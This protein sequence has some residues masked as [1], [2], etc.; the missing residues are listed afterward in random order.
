MVQEKSDWLFVFHPQLQACSI[1]VIQEW[2]I[3][4]AA[5]CRS[6]QKSNIWKTNISKLIKK[7]INWCI[8]VIKTTIIVVPVKTKKIDVVK[9]VKLVEI[10]PKWDKSSSL[11]WKTKAINSID[12]IAAK[13]F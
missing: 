12:E 7:K 5:I 13:S 4:N 2:D 9:N 10:E 11:K 8:V 3:F 6:G 1:E